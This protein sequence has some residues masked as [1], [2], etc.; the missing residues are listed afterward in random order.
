VILFGVPE[1]VPAYKRMGQRVRYGY[2]DGPV[3]AGTRGRIVGFIDRKW[4][5]RIRFDNGVEATCEVPSYDVV[6]RG[7]K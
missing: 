7:A 2:T 5:A 6:K 3:P 4:A 1:R